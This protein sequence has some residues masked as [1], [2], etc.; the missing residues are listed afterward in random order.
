MQA[1][2]SEGYEKWLVS[3]YSLFGTKFSKMLCGPMWSQ[4]STTQTGQENVVFLD[5]I[6]VHV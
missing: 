5:P 4:V 3:M 1:V 6:Q 2:C